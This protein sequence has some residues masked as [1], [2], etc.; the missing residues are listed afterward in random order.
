MTSDARTAAT[1]VPRG[2]LLACAV[3]RRRFPVD[4]SPQ[5]GSQRP[6]WR[7]IASGRRWPIGSPDT[8]NLLIDRRMSAPSINEMALPTHSGHS[9]YA[10]A[11]TRGPTRSPCRRAPAVR[12]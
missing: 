12:W 6:V 7:R 4:A 9:H 3:Q 5:S 1:D 10:E 11:D 2:P 8:Y